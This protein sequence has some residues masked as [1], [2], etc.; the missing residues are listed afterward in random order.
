MALLPNRAIPAAAGYP[1]YSGSVVLP[2]QYSQTLIENF[3]AVTVF[4]EIS[5]TDYLGELN[6]K[7]DQITFMLDPCVV[8]RDSVKGAPITHDTVEV[9]S[10]TLVI[11]RAKEY[12]VKVAKVDLQMSD[13]LT[14]LRDRFVELAPRAIQEGV[15]CELMAEMIANVDP[16]NRGATAGCISGSYNMGV[17]NTPF[18]VTPS[19]V[20]AFLT[21]M[22]AVL[23]EQNIPAEGRFVVVPTQMKVALMNSDLKAAYFSGESQSTYLNGK[24][25]ERQIAGFTIYVSNR[26][27]KGIDP[28]VSKLAYSM[29]FG[30]NTAT[31]FASVLDDSRQIEDAD[32]WD[33]Y[34]Q[35]LMAYG[36]GVVRPKA[37]GVAYATFN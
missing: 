11:D 1:Q 30:I 5:T 7:G 12:S 14:R 13:R 3:Y 27:P 32:S 6:G 35:G 20:L 16:A 22:S 36:F 15:D 29:P 17:L 37:L 25:A 8:V 21:N 9:N 31:T 2:P 19:N 28:G 34:V 18:A 23:D 4:S 26:V 24:I 10:I 33:V